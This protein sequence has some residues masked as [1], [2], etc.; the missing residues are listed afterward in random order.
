[1]R[2]LQWMLFCKD[3]ETSDIRAGARIRSS[4]V[5]AHVVNVPWRP[6]PCPLNTVNPKTPDAVRT[7]VVTVG[8]TS[9]SFGALGFFVIC[10]CEL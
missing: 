5:R 10:S 6:L 1:M 8:F 3:S 2:P 7:C 4:Q 9:E